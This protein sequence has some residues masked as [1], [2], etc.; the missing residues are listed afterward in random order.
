M[1]T[2]ESLANLLATWG[3]PYVYYSYRGVLGQLAGHL[4]DI[5]MYIMVTGES[6]ANLLATW[7][8]PYVYYVYRG[9]LGHLAGH[10]GTPL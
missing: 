1:V 6:L 5:L 2:G 9:V 3:H 4:G 10:M 8:R 7:G